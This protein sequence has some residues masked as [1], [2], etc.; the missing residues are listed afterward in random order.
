MSY[1]VIVSNARPEFDPNKR[2]HR[3][4]ALWHGHSMIEEVFYKK[5]VVEDWRKRYALHRE[6]NH[7]VF[8]I[9]RYV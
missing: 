7:P 4:I 2:S 6:K 9:I 8:M 5:S 3:K 1:H